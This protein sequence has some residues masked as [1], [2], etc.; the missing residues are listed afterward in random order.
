LSDGASA[1]LL[2]KD[3]PGLQVVDYQYRFDRRIRQNMLEGTLEG[4]A[5]SW[6]LMAALAN[7]VKA[8]MYAKHGLDNSQISQLITNYS[9]LTSRDIY[10]NLLDFEPA[11]TFI[12]GIEDLGH[13]FS[14]ELFICIQK[15]L[16]TAKA[17]FK[18]GSY[19]LL[20]FTSEN[21]VGLALLKQGEEHE[22]Q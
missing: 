8:K 2:S 9:G 6:K 13:M 19:I 7:D 22:G 10:A 18:K 4:T 16:E 5:Q 17:P 14:G 20:L 15:Y 21:G 11:D 1:C 12:D 3:V